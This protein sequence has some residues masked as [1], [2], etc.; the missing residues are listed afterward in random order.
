MSLSRIALWLRFNFIPL[1]VHLKFYFSVTYKFIKL[2]VIGLFEE[3][4]IRY[5]AI[6][7]GLFY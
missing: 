7:T 2:N 5:I 6:G 1:L 3:R 4:I